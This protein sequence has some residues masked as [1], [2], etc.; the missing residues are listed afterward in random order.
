MGPKLVLPSRVKE[1]LGVLAIKTF[2]E[3]LDL[4]N[5]SLTNKCSFIPKI[6]LE[7]IFDKIS[8]NAILNMHFPLT[9]IVV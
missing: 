3:P 4:Q 7:F 6:L 8:L 5:W 2:F 1:N 9:H